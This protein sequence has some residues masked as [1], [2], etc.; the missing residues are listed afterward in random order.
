M[1]EYLLFKGFVEVVVEDCV[2]ETPD[3]WRLRGFVSGFSLFKIW[4]AKLLGFD[5]SFLLTVDA[6]WTFFGTRSSSETSS[7]IILLAVLLP[8]LPRD[9]T[10]HL[11]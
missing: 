9:I 5:E 2:D 4:T 7:G 10:L 1:I 8:K 6:G 11:Q 3:F